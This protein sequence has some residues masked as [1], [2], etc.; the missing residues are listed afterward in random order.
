[1][2]DTFQAMLSLNV[3]NISKNTLKASYYN[4]LYLHPIFINMFL[5]GE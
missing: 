4:K 1:M 3:Y 5:K 2:T